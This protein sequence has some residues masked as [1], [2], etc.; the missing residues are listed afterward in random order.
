VPRPI[1][2]GRRPGASRARQD[3]Q[4]DVSRL[5]VTFIMTIALY[6][7]EFTVS[8]FILCFYCRRRLAPPLAAAAVEPPP[9]TQIAPASSPHPC[10]PRG[11]TG[12]AVFS[13]EPP[14]H[15]SPCPTPVGALPPPPPRGQ[16]TP[17]RRRRHQE[18]HHDRYEPLNVFLALF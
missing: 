6:I 15:H 5:P 8:H 16:A 2:A 13:P 11:P 3:R 7:T 9:A 10:A 12:L 1:T 4:C 17:A 18:H 14:H